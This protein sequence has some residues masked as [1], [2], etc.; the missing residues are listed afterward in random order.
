MS[1]VLKRN[2][3][4]SFTSAHS[5]NALG[6]PLFATN[7]SGIETFRYGTNGRPM[8]KRSAAMESMMRSLGTEAVSEFKSSKPG[9]DGILYMMFRNV[10]PDII[11]LYIGKAELFGKSN[12][13][14]SANISDLISGVSMFGRWGYNYAYHIGDLSAATLTGHPDSKRTPKYSKWSS[15]LFDIQDG[16]IKPKFEIRF[17]ATLWS[18]NSQSVWSNYGPTKLAFEEYLLIGIAS[19]LFPDDLLNNEGRNR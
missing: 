8:L 7:A 9:C 10:G 4:M 3:W 11:P 5:I 18:A 19:D 6:V 15:K 16:C 14:L 1:E 13:N 17:W 2:L 12:R